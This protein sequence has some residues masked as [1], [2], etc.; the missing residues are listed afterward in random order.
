[1]VLEICREFGNNIR[2]LRKAAGYS[3]ERFAEAIEIGTTSLS[4]VETGKG[5]VTAKTLTKI[6]D[7]LKVD[8]AQLFTYVKDDNIEDYYK[9]ILDKVERLKDNKEKLMLLDAYINLL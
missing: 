3:Q 8:V 7:T 9:N 6:A 2:R 5:F 1:M 4:L